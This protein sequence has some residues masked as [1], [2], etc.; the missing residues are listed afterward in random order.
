MGSLTVKEIEAK[1][2]Q[3]AIG[4]HAD[5]DGLYLVIPKSGD[6]YWMLRYSYAGKRKEMTLAKYSDLKLADARLKAAEQMKQVRLGSDPIQAKRQAAQTRVN[7]VQDLF[8]DWYP[9]LEKRLKH[10]EIP[11]RIFSK[12]IAPKVGKISLNDVTPVDIRDLLR[13]ITDSGRPTIANDALMYCKQLFNHGIK[14][15]LISFNPASAFSVTDAG[16][17]EKSKDRALTLEELKQFFAVAAQ[18]PV[19]FGRD[20]YLA[21]ALLVTLG[22]RKSELTEA[23]WSEFDLTEY[24]WNLP[25]S[26][27]K[28]GVGITIPLPPIVMEWLKELEVRACGSNYVFPNRRQGKKEH[29]GTDTLNRAISKLFGRDPGKAKKPDNLMG[30]I[31]H[32]TVHDLRRTCRSLLARQGTSGDVAERCLNHKLKGVEGIYNRHDYLEERRAALEK[33]SETIAELVN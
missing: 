25:A 7:T 32:F 33:L 14:L 13:K 22:V 20:N 17:I 4:R 2:R 12:D 1:L 10:P 11:L 19:Y 6:P 31:P 16:G 18:N 8:D 24:E 27:S 30:D 3:S 15:G 5:G 23:A 9:G 21:C 29:M 28:S 26:R